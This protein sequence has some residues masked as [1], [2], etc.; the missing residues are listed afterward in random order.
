MHSVTQSFLKRIDQ[1]IAKTRDA[2]GYGVVDMWVLFQCLAL[3][4]IGETAFGQTFNMIENNDHFVPRTI[5]SGMKVAQY[6][7]ISIYIYVGSF[8][9]LNYIF[10]SHH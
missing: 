1:E 9:L 8:L 4:I 10:L 3:D 6:V 2:D 5:T 7:S